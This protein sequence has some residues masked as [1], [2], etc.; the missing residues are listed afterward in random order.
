MS[1][2]P[3]D[4]AKGEKPEIVACRACGGPC[5]ETGGTVSVTPGVVP[6]VESLVK[7]MVVAEGLLEEA[8]LAHWNATVTQRSLCVWKTEPDASGDIA[9]LVIRKEEPMPSERKASP[10]DEADDLRYT[11]E[12]KE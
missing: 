2:D 3:E 4:V 8:D 1:A 10:A 9:V 11:K 12:D 7:G 6:A 5:R